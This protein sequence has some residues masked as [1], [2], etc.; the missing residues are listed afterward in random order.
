PYLSTIAHHCWLISTIRRHTGCRT[1]HITRNGR[2]KYSHIDHFCRLLDCRYSNSIPLWR[3]LGHWGKRRLVR[4]Y[5]GLADI[6]VA[7]FFT[8]QVYHQTPHATRP[9]VRR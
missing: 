8:L 2:C 3:L 6:F 1:W 7:T 4:T 5:L 9:A